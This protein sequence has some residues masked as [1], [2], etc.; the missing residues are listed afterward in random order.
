M[1]QATVLL[2]CSK[3]AGKIS[4]HAYFS[5]KKRGIGI[6]EPDRNPKVGAPRRRCPK[7]QP[8]SGVSGLAKSWTAKS[9]ILGY[10]QWADRGVWALNAV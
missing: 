2:I 8:Q 3:L 5:L 9:F 6:P 7:L 10:A 4:L 1:G